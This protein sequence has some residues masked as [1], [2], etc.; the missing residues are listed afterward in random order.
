[1]GWKFPFQLHEA[2]PLKAKILLFAKNT[3]YLPR[4]KKKNKKT[5]LSFKSEGRSGLLISAFTY[6]K[7]LFSISI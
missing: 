1:M 6:M 3:C 2:M 7:N 4:K 5:Q